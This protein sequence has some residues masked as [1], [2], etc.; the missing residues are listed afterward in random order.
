MLSVV[1]LQAEHKQ[2]RAIVQCKGSTKC[3]KLAKNKEAMTMQTEQKP[4]SIEASIREARL[5][6]GMP[7]FKCEVL[8]GKGEPAKVYRTPKLSV[9][10]REQGI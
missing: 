10:D 4:R 7:P 2:Q 3:S 1:F 9:H 5:Q 6:Y 8:Q